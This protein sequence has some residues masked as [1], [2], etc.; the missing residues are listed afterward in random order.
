MDFKQW[1]L[2]EKPNRIVNSLPEGRIVTWRNN[3]NDNGN[4]K[5]TSSAK[6]M[7]GTILSAS[8]ILTL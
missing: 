6:N 1:M 5:Y 2:V 4:K 3:I 8:H 7:P